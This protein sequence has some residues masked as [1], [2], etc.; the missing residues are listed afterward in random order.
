[1][2]ESDLKT[3]IG[4]ATKAAM[5]ARDK[6]RVATLRLIN[7]DIQRVEV[8]ERRE[9]SDQDVITILTRMVKQRQDS[10][11]HY[12]KAGRDDLATQ[13]RFEIGVVREFLPQPLEEAEVEALIDA[14]I[15]RSGAGSMKDMGKVMG[16]LKP[17]MEG[18]VD[19]GAVS[20]KVKQKL[21]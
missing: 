10:L 8:D 17:Q 5:K 16:L 4:E 2:P 19:M 1:M 6:V 15:A 13:E 7:A 18:R 3:Q 14:A 20:G 11:T 21:A 12:E 9:L